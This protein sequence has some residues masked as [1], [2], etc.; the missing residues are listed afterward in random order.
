MNASPPRTSHQPDHAAD[1]RSAD[2]R[3]PIHPLWVLATGL[4]ALSGAR[5]IQH[6]PVLV[7]ACGLRTLTGIPCPLC[8]STRCLIAWSHLEIAE[9]FR[10]NPMVAAGCVAV[11]VWVLLSALDIF[12]GR[13]WACVT[14]Q[15]LHRRPWPLILAAAALVNWVYLILWL[16]R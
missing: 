3:R 15:H 7:P 5:L 6:L 9:A 12:C 8:G 13:N 14:T 4:V 11:G 1:S 2:G 10:F 16:P